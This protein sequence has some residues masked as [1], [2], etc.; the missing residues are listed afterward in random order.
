MLL[1]TEMSSSEKGRHLGVD[2][3]DRKLPYKYIRI[4]YRHWQNGIK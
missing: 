1:N 4:T 2:V 3:T